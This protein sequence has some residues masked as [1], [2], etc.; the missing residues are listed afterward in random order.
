MYFS[1]KIIIKI[2]IQSHLYQIPNQKTIIKA[3]IFKVLINNRINK[4]KK[5]LY[6]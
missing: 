6:Y 1:R 3:V 5:K 2:I 4:T